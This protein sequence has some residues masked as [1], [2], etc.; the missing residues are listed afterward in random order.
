MI[1]PAIL[2]RD[3]DRIADRIAQVVA[4]PG[5]SRFHIDFA[6][7]RFVPDLTC[8]IADIAPLNPEFTWQAHLMAVSPRNLFFDAQIAGFQSVAIHAEAFAASAEL[9]AAAEELKGM[10]ISPVLALNPET[11][12]SAVRES[13]AVF[14]EVIVLCVEPGKQGQEFIPAALGKLAEITAVAPRIKLSV[15]GGMHSGTVQLAAAAGADFL[16][17]GSAIFANTEAGDSTP[18]QNFALLESS[19]RQ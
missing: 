5:A 2:E 9:R 7:G 16:I 18:A 4:F 15:D 14:D 8:A 10:H 19:L 3:P 12:V 11:P 13:L 1:V 6:D 17:A